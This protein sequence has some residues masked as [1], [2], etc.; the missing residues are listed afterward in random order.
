[1]TTDLRWYEGRLS[2]HMVW[3]V[4][5]LGLLYVAL[6]RLAAG[7][8]LWETAK[9]VLPAVVI[10]WYAFTAHWQTTFNHRFIRYCQREK[11][12]GR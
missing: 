8:T 7:A 3:V 9:A 4:F 2:F 12:H 10:L 6:G 1:V 11:T 5:G